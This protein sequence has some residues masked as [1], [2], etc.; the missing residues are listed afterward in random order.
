MNK[1]SSGKVHWSTPHHVVQHVEHVFGGVIQLDPC[2]NT[3][4]P[5]RAVY[6]WTKTRTYTNGRKVWDKSPE[7][8]LHWRW[9]HGTYVNPPHGDKAVKDK[10]LKEA[11]RGTRMM[12]CVPANTGTQFMQSLMSYGLTKFCSPRVAF[13]DPVTREPCKGVMHDTALVFCNGNPEENRRHHN[14]SFVKGIVK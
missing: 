8:T 2:W 4:S 11:A 12:V 6:A 10:I 5:V 7:D 9:D 3:I 1:T 13:V 14:N